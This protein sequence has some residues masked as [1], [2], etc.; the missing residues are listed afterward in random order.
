MLHE[1]VA[2]GAGQAALALC[3]HYV[4]AGSCVPDTGV[5]SKGGAVQAAAG[6]TPL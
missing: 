2:Y 4:A 3:K 5:C 6:G 1:Q